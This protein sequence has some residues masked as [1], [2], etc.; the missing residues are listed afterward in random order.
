VRCQGGCAA[1]GQADD[2]GGELLELRHVAL[3]AFGEG[4]IV[5]G[6]SARACAL[7]RLAAVSSPQSRMKFCIAA[8]SWRARFSGTFSAANI[9]RSV[10]RPWKNNWQSTPQ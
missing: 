9:A 5:A 2:L 6:L 1:Q 4:R 3:Q 8:F 10:S 7:P